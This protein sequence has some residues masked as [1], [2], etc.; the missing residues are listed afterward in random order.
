L[1]AA[2]SDFLAFLL[3]DAFSLLPEEEEEAKVSA[4]VLFKATADDKVLLP[5]SADV[6]S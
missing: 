6:E 4:E 5:R 2:C 1:L 3:G